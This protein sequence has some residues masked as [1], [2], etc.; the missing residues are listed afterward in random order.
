[1]LAAQLRDPHRAEVELSQSVALDPDNAIVIRQAAIAYEAL[2]QREHTLA[3]L[4]HAADSLLEELADQPDM[5]DLQN[6]RR[7]LELLRWHKS[8]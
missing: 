4:A 6:D 3:L 7:F 8:R 2:G 1:M 5:K